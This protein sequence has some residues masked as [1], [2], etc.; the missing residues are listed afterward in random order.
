MNTT[1]FIAL[2]E[3]VPAEVKT[4][5]PGGSAYEEECVKIKNALTPAADE[6]MLFSE[7]KKLRT[8]FI[9]LS[10]IDDTKDYSPYY[11]I[12][13]KVSDNFNGSTHKIADWSSDVWKGG[14]SICQVSA[15]IPTD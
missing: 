1:E 9:Y 15:R 8:G 2:C 10:I 3:G 6:G 7:F 13:E 11:Y 4:S 14:Y 12:L 5:A